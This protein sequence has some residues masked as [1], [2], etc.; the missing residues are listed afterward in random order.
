VRDLAG[1]PNDLHSWCTFTTQ[2]DAFEAAPINCVTH[3]TA[4]AYCRSLGKDLPTEAQLE[5]IASGR[6]QERGYPWGDDEPSCADAVF[7]RD[8]AVYAGRRLGFAGDCRPSDSLGGALTPG[9]GSRDRVAIKGDDGSTREVVD[10]AGNLSEPVLDRFSL[11][12][13]AFW[14]RAGVFIDPVADLVGDPA[15]PD[16]TRGGDWTAQPYALR[17]AARFGEPPNAL[18][19]SLGM[20][21]ARAAKP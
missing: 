13:D 1:D 9:A 14:G 20:R 18:G 3:D 17:A 21:C 5:F 19:P 4:R 2:P 10:L 6:G 12:G 16:T 8:S 15:L 11:P 7:A